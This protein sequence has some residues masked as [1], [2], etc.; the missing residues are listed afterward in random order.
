MKLTCLYRWTI[1]YYV[2]KKWSLKLKLKG[3]TVNTCTNTW[4]CIATQTVWC[5]VVVVVYTY[6]IRV[7]AQN[8]SHNPQHANSMTAGTCKSK[9][10]SMS[11]TV[12]ERTSKGFNYTSAR[13]HILL[14]TL[15]TIPPPTTARNIRE[16]FK[17]HK[18]MYNYIV[19]LPFLPWHTFS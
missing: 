8:F 16:Q 7:V 17:T 1:L 6:V 14:A 5:M 12:D 19:F 3:A 11:K 13:C 10:I 18:H 15:H 4:M 2:C 9:D